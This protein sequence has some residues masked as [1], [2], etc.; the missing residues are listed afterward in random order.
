MP[1]IESCIN[2]NL[3]MV[4]NDRNR[5]IT[6]FNFKVCSPTVPSKSFT[7]YT[8]MDYLHDICKWEAGGHT[9]I[10]KMVMTLFLKILT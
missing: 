10:L 7:L 6:I 8:D 4:K 1:I 3:F 5:V 2:A 9:L